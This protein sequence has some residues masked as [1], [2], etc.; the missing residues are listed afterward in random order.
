MHDTSPS[1]DRALGRTRLRAV[2]PGPF[3][4]ARRV[5]RSET[6]EAARARLDATAVNSAYRAALRT[7][8][9]VRPVSLYDFLR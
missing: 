5:L 3:A 8:A 7:T 6:D 4:S 1:R 9:T 2:R